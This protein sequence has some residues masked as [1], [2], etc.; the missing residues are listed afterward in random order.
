[1]T[2][3]HPKLEELVRRDP[4]FPLE[5]YE[6]VREAVMHAMRGRGDADL[7]ARQLLAAVPELARREFGMMA[8]TVFRLWGVNST[9]DLGEIVANLVSAGLMSAGPN[10]CRDEFR[11]AYD[12]DAALSGE[13][14][15]DWPPERLDA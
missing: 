12:L 15:I 2:M 14:S 3:H 8:R 13:F 10:D 6:F 11:A 4:R 5:A 9:E 7:S 1:M